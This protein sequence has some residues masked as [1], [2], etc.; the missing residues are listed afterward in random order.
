MY[1]F[2]HVDALLD[3]LEVGH[4][5]RDVLAALVKY[6]MTNGEFDSNT[7]KDCSHLLNDS[8]V[9][10]SKIILLKFIAKRVTDMS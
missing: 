9:S 10:K 7:D 5:L 3:G 4:Q 1:L 2:R 8:Y 6:F